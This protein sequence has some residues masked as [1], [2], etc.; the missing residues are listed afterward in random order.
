MS[1]RLH[2]ADPGGKAVD[3]E[4]VAI[5][6][7]AAEA[8]EGGSCRERVMA[9]VLARMDIADVNFDGRDLHRDQRIMKCNRGVRVAAGVDDDAGRLLCNVRRE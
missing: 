3:R 7:E 9:E 5:N 4:P 2:R 8:C 1:P 6:S